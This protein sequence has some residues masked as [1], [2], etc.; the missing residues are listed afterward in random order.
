VQDL[1]D[2]NRIN[3]G[4]EGYGQEG[5]EGLSG[6]AFDE[7]V[8]NELW[9]S[10]NSENGKVI[11]D[12]MATHNLEALISDVESPAMNVA[13]LAGYPG[14]MVPSGID[15]DGLPT[16][17]LFFGERWSDDRLLAFAYSYEQAS[18]ALQVPTFR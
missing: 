18:L 1:I 6:I 8:Y 16:S 4:P 14:I 15:A 9:R 11:D 17:V 12:L 2:F 7:A 5:L 3:P 13:S 10:I